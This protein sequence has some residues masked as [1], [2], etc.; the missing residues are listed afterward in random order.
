MKY[1]YTI[2]SLLAILFSSCEKEETPV[3]LPPRDSSVQMTSVNMGEEYGNQ[4][5]FNIDNGQ[6]A[7]VDNNLWDLSFDATPSGFSIYINGGKNVLVA[8][9]GS[10][11]FRS[12]IKT[13]DLKWRWDESSGKP[14]SLVLGRWCNWS[15]GKSYDS[16]YVIDRG[17]GKDKPENFYQFRIKQVTPQKYL[18]SVSDMNGVEL[19]EVSVI[20]NPV[21]T[22]VYFSFSG[23]GEFVDF[24]PAKHTWHFTFL[25]Y[26]WIYYEY[27]PPLLYQ[28]CGIHLNRHMV[29]VAVDST[30]SFY[31]IKREDV[32][33]LH[34]ADKRDIIGFDWKFPDFT[35]NGVRYRTRTYVNYIIREKGSGKIYKLRF[36]DFY[37]DQGRKGAPRF[38][39]QQLK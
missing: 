4:I 12:G 16:V 15:S 36:L 38:E 3:T 39:Y 22:L 13:A 11:Q 18:V 10:N 33:G 9:T 24:E 28:V 2:L 6:T 20:K 17:L 35:P 5:F 31:Q 14:D 7:V 32:M 21:K 8:N 29:D 19:K 27:N 30:M 25:R 37:D 23:G 26:R 34:Y 1:L